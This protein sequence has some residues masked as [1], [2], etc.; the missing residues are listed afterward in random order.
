MKVFNNILFLFFAIT[1]AACDDILE[2]DI[3][4]DVINV[5]TP[6]EGHIVESNIV[7][8]QWETLKGANKYR[9]Q[10][11]DKNALLIRDTLTSKT[12]LKLPLLPGN[13]KFK[14]RGE[15]L[16]YESKYTTLTSFE[17][18]SPTSL[19][20]QLVILKSPYSGFS[21]NKNNL[22]LVWDPI[23]IAASYT[24][25]LYDV[26][27]SNVLL[28]SKE[29]ITAST[30]SLDSNNLKTDAL[31]EWR[32]KAVNATSVTDFNKATFLLDTTPPNA[33]QNIFPNNADTRK[34]NTVIDFSWKLDSD[35]GIIKSPIDYYII[36]FATDSDFSR[37]LE[38]QIIN[39][40]SC[41]KTFATTGT[42]FWRVK[43][44][45]KAGNI[46]LGYS[47]PF[48]LLIN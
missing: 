16:G 45:D 6:K 25:E 10:I 20:N 1:I 26:T 2:K 21:T 44:K 4:T 27:N 15:N 46:G 3:T 7:S 40:T 35:S 23:K 14:I 39:T 8:F 22:T 37:G 34:V 38:S 31:Y 42:F 32:V 18:K 47:K 48:S 28:F 41:Q 9:L 33:P 43:A 29:G 30:Y 36:E 11:E 5:V 12:F 13:Y 24:L 19:E 17:I